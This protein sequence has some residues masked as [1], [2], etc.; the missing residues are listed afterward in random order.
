MVILLSLLGFYWCSYVSATFTLIAIV[1]L[2]FKTSNLKWRIDFELW[3]SLMCAICLILTV[4]L[5]VCLMSSVKDKTDTDTKNFYK[6]LGIE[7]DVITVDKEDV[8]V[9]L[10]EWS[11]LYESCAFIVFIL[12]FVFCFRARRNV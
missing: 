1:M 8:A 6:S 11:F 4:V 7:F 5:K 12:W 10:Y 9:P 2:F 3:T